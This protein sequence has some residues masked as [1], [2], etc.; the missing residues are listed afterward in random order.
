M[1]KRTG[2]NATKLSDQ[3]ALIDTGL[4]EGSLDIGLGLKQMISR[5]LHGLDRWT[6]AA[7]ISK[8][9]GIEISKDTLDKRLSSDPSYQMYAIHLT[10]IA[11]ITSN[12]KPFQYLLE[13]L[14][15]DVLDPAD[16]DLIELARI[17][18]KI[19]L[20]DSERMRILQRRGLEVKP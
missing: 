15:S 8:A 3:M 16:R 7:Q 2:H 4:A 5:E 11:A 10:A 9:T 6:I 18:E 19:K 12:L 20:L 1:T 17:Q 13:P 14:G